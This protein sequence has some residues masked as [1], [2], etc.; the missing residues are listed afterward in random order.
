ME[1]LLDGKYVVRVVDGA[2]KLFNRSTGELVP[3]DVPK[4]LFL[5]TDRVFNPAILQEYR[6]LCERDGC[7]RSHLDGLVGRLHAFARFL[8]DQG[9]RMKQ[10]D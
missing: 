8:E 5:A 7:K 4:I 10:P 6:R 9:G 3:D 1:L 2:P